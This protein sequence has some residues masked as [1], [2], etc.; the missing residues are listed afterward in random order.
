MT[1]T[2]RH[3]LRLTA[4]AMAAAFAAGCDVHEFPTQETPPAVVES[5]LKLTFDGVDMPLHT[6]VEFDSDG[7]R[8]RS[9]EEGTRDSRH[10][11]NVY[12]DDSRDEERGSGT[13]APSRSAAATA[14]VTDRADAATDDR[15]VAI[16]LPP[17][18][19]RY[20]AWSDYVEAGS[21]ADLYYDT[22]DFSEIALRSA[23]SPSEA[24]IHRGNSPWR[25]AFRG[26]GRFRVGA[27]GAMYAPDDRDCT[28]PLAE[29]VITMRR[30]LARYVFDRYP[31]KS[32]LK[33]A[34]ARCLRST[35]PT[36]ASCS[37]TQATC[38]R[39][40]TPTSTNPST[41]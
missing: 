25:D 4:A 5:R 40:T 30:P 2:L 9:A 1:A 34:P 36:S 26:E 8:A 41:P 12:V 6:T 37:A 35:C 32:T 18:S 39:S 27:D 24:Y 21:D 19:Y 22:S 29:A 13:R 33:A 38:P 11:I 31:T 17:G 3:I 10:I 7:R 16:S 15:S 20:V 28:T 14:T 23:G